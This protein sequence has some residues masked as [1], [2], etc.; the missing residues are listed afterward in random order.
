MAQD[1]RIIQSKTELHGL[2]QG[3]EITAANVLMY[4]PMY[5]L[6]PLP[7]WPIARSLLGLEFFPH[8]ISLV[9]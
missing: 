6:I 2:R 8:G 1:A 5:L 3:A 7:M 9:S 4:L